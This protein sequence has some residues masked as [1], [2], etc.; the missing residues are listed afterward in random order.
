MEKQ[1]LHP[2]CL[3][4]FKFEKTYFNNALETLRK[5]IDIDIIDPKEFVG[6]GNFF[7]KPILIKDNRI[8]YVGENA[9]FQDA[10]WG[11]GLKY[12]MLSAYLAA[13]SIINK[14]DYV[15]LCEIQILNKFKTSLANRWIFSHLYNWGYSIF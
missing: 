12:S 3:R 11:F 14:N 8:L 9:G 1:L 6:F 10:L 7:N 15:D 13:Q 4:I 5:V 2:V